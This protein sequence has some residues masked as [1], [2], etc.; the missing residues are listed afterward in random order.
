MNNAYIREILQKFD[1]AV[2]QVSSGWSGRYSP[3][4][5]GGSDPQMG[6][7]IEVI[8]DNKRVYLYDN[9]NQTRVEENPSSLDINGPSLYYELVSNFRRFLREDIDYVNQVRF[10]NG[11]VTLDLKEVSA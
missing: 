9:L 8:V 10:F 2:F 1:H 3:N 11:T 6:K 4:S 7:R 5:M